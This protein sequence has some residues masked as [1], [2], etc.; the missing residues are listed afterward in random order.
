MRL[1]P[2][3]MRSQITAFN[4]VKRGTS[5]K[6]TEHYFSNNAKQ[7]VE[8]NEPCYGQFHYANNVKRTSI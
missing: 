3:I 5:F 7:E 4:T 6:S 8:N 1:V 2:S